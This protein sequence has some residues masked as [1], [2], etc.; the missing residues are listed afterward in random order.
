[1]PCVGEKSAVLFS[2]PEPSVSKSSVL[3]SVL[4]FR[5]LKTQPSV[6]FS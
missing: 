1:M 6:F 2:P 5:P 4:T 3:T